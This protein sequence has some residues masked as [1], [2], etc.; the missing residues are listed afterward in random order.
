MFRLGYRWREEKK[1]QYADGHEREDV[2]TYRQNIFLP[3]WR[4]FED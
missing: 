1:G 2:V 3:L 4:S